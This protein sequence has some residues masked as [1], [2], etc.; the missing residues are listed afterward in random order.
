MTNNRG[1]SQLHFSSQRKG[2]RRKREGMGTGDSV[3]SIS[4]RAW[5]LSQ[6]NLFIIGA[7]GLKVPSNQR[8]MRRYAW[9]LWR[10]TRQARTQLPFLSI[11]VFLL[12]LVFFWKDDDAWVKAWNSFAWFVSCLVASFCAT[13][14]KLGR[15]YSFLQGSVEMKCGMLVDRKTVLAFSHSFFS[16]IK[17][18]LCE[19]RNVISNQA[20][21]IATIYTTI[22]CV[23]RAKQKCNE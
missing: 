6:K 18:F 11:S 2:T 23:F 19:T 16:L 13:N 17:R 3:R 12:S 21:T 22:S 1:G 15:N 7:K 4:N 9:E 14:A 20:N 8:G 10:H 5:V